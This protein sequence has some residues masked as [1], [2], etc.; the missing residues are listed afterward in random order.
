MHHHAVGLGD[1]DQ[2]VGVD[3]PFGRQPVVDVA[4]AVGDVDDREPRGQGLPGGP[5]VILP[6]EALLV[7]GGAPAAVL[8]AALL[9][10]VPGPELLG[11]QP[12]RQAVGADQEGGVELQAAAAGAVGVTETGGLFQGGEVEVGGVLEGQDA[13][14]ALEALQGVGQAG[15]DDGGRGD[16]VGVGAY[17]LARMKVWTRGRWLW[18]RTIGST[19]LGQA[20]D[21]MIFYPLAFAGIWAG[22]TLFEVIAFNWFFKVMVEVVMTPVTSR[23][24]RRAQTP[25]ARNF[26]QHEHELHTV[27]ARRLT[28][29]TAAST[30]T[31]LHSG[32]AVLG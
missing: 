2:Q 21:S 25:R 29:S 24:R 1:A 4:L 27:L 3:R 23:D 32:A 26:Y 6:A 17:V 15:G 18:T 5:G 13:C 7:L 10:R 11:E 19:I 22:E 20:V 9:R 30:G 12:G 8:D 14:A 16:A 28:L 31:G